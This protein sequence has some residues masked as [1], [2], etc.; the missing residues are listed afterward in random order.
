MGQSICFPML[1]C[2]LRI[3]A[4]LG[5]SGTCSRGLPVGVEGPRIPKEAGGVPAASKGVYSLR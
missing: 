3:R 5:F 4:G 2:D 1:N